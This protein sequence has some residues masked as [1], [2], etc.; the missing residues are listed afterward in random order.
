[1]LSKYAYAT[2]HAAAAATMWPATIVTGVLGSR[3]LSNTAARDVLQ[4]LHIVFFHASVAHAAALASGAVA[5]AC[6]R[7]NIIFLYRVYLR[8][9]LATL[10]NVTVSL[11]YWFAFFRPRMCDSDSVCATLA[12]V[13]YCYLVVLAATGVLQTTALILSVY[14]YVTRRYANWDR[15]HALEALFS[16]HPALVEGDSCR[17]VPR[18]CKFWTRQTSADIVARL[19]Q[20][21]AEVMDAITRDLDTDRDGVVSLREFV[22]FAMAHGVSD[23]DQ[24]DQIWDILSLTSDSSSIT[25]IGVERALYDLC[26]YRR[27]LALLL[28]TDCNVIKWAM[29]YLSALLYS[30]TAVIAL[31]ILGYDSFGAGIDLFKVWLLIVTYAI[32]NMA[33]SITFVMTMIR[34]RPFN[35]GD[36]LMMDGAQVGLDID[37]TGGN[38]FQVA[39]ITPRFTSLQGC[40]PLQVP[41]ALLI[42]RSVRNVST[43]PLNDS[44]SIKLPLTTSNDLPAR[45]RAA[46]EGYA[47]LHPYDIDPG[48]LAHNQVWGELGVDHKTLE[49]YWTY[50]PV[51]H[52]GSYAKRMMFRVRNAILDRIWR[53]VREDALVISSASG[54]AFNQQVSHKHKIE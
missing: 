35:L 33:P 23:A 48:S 22:R 34:H 25:R 28:L 52:D 32:N 7:Y 30:G 41:N 20:R 47:A 50:S 27:R 46:I 17:D 24:I 42:N 43:A 37:R 44:V 3:D 8:R 45:V 31:T 18:F 38:F 12:D 15:M 29:R 49:C 5:H 39:K 19:P 51:V 40:I 2:M 13:Y 36:V 21:S 9:L 11:P 1:M 54:G 6:T 14:T 53:E 16:F 10:L 26:F 4:I